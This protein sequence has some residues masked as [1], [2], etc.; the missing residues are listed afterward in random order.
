[1]EKIDSFCGSVIPKPIM[2]N[3]PK[4]TLHFRSKLPPRFPRGF[5]A[6]YSF[7]EGKS[8]QMSLT[9]FYTLCIYSRL[10]D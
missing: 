3:G 6:T 5:N 4:L 8:Q 9:F 10:W 2:S 7:T 1:M